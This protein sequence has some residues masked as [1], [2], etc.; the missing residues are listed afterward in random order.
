MAASH[1]NS[2]DLPHGG[3]SFIAPPMWAESSGQPLS[4]EEK[5]VL[6]GNATV[7]RF[8][9]GETIF[10]RAEPASAVFSIIDG[11]VKLYRAQPGQK[12][13]IVRFMFANELIGLSETGY[14]INSAKSI[15]PTRLYRMP[16]RALES[17]VPQSPSLMFHVIARLCHD[18][19]QT[20]DHA[21]LLARHH[22]T[23]RIALFVQMLAAHQDPTGASNADLY[24]PMTR[25]D[26]GAYVGISPE[27]VGR[28][29][30]E[31]VSCGAVLF[32]DR[33]HLKI[34]DRARLE[35]VIAGTER[36]GRPTKAG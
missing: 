6:A 33:R 1:E 18:L 10:N 17:R 15:T 25:T 36:P 24:L 13:H 9:K 4:D 30:S 22:A 16:V 35:A 8:K 26:I 5:A 19:S 34:V 12:E 31:L 23:T 21:L 28:G 32:T 29:F 11:V 20:Q 2:N 14:Y 3:P 27:A 7:V